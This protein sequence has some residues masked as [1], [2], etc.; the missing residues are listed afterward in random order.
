MICT[1]T[2]NPSLDYFMECDQEVQNNVL[3]RSS[4][5]YYQAGGK[6]INVSIVLNNLGI[7]TRA[8]GF[9]G[10]FTKDFYIDLLARYEY[11][12]PNFTYTNGHT[13][14]NVKLHNKDMATTINA[15]GPYITNSDMDNLAAKISRL[16]EGDYLVLAGN[17]QPYLM[18]EVKKMLKDAIAEK[19]KVCMDTDPQLM[20]EMVQ[21]GLF[22]I[23]TTPGELSQLVG[24]TLQGEQE[25]LDSAKQLHADGVENVMVV[26]DN[27][28]G[29]LV[30]K[31][32]IFKVQLP[33]AANPMYAVGTGDSMVAG[34][35]M[36]YMRSRDVLESFRFGA[37]CGTANVYSKGFASRERINEYFEVT[38]VTKLES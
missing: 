30:C 5:E 33:N 7:P 13:R 27:K 23:K 35:L 8:F 34:F 24:K 37:A 3:N 4:L 1:C 20:K 2:L 16:T 15:A 22:L 26:S 10:G 31:E 21:E 29:I 38:E 14:I 9:I 11:I 32:G 28:D 12:R 17:T 18:D 19:V 6:G 25:I 36:D